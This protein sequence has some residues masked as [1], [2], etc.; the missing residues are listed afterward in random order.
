MSDLHKTISWAP[1]QCETVATPMCRKSWVRKARLE[2]RFV[3]KRCP[4]VCNGMQIPCI[5]HWSV[6]KKTL[7][8]FFSSYFIY[9]ESV[10]KWQ[11]FSYLQTTPWKPPSKATRMGVLFLTNHHNSCHT[12]P[13]RKENTRLMCKTFP[14]TNQQKSP[15]A[16]LWLTLDK[17]V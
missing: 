3:G 14:Q 16:G 7:W 6:K 8:T 15:S 5:L 2:L 10:Q 13:P 1:H 4:L 11:M 9:S 12:C 17:N